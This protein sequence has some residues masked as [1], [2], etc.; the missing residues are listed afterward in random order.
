MQISMYTFFGYLVVM[1]GVTYLIRVI[2]FA[3]CQG[4]IKNRFIQSFLTYVPYAVLAAMT[5]PSIWYS[6]G[7]LASGLAATA[8]ALILAYRRKSLLTVAL[9]AVTVA[10]FVLLIG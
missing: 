6:T 10:F 1:A 9:A 4:E 2:P 3:L 7:G 8:T 5:F